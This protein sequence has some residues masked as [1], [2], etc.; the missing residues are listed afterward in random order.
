MKGRIGKYQITGQIG[1]GGMGKIYK[2]VGPSSNKEIIIKQLKVSAK[3]V[4]VKRFQREADIMSRFSHPNIVKVFERFSDDGFSYIAMEYID[5]IS[6]EELIKKR[7]VLSTP[8]SLLILYQVCQGLK[9]AHDRGVIHRDIKPDN[10]LISKR[11]DVKLC[12]FGIAGGQPGKDEPLTNTGVVMGTPAY[13]S[14]EQL[15]SAKYLDIRSDIY[16]LGVAFYQMI[17]GC[18][19]FPS[20][21]SKETVEKIT[22]GIFPK[23]EKENPDIPACFRQIIRKTMNRKIQKRYQDLGELIDYLA[24]FLDEFNSRG[25]INVAIKHYV[26]GKEIKFSAFT[27]KTAS[28]RERQKTRIKSPALNRG[29]NG[30]SGIVFNDETYLFNGKITV[31]RAQNNNIVIRDDCMVSRRHAELSKENGKCFMVDFSVN[32]TYLNGKRLAK[33]SKTPVCSGDIV[34]LGKSI[35]EIR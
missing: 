5:G 31:G 35:L 28:N 19:P 1:Q 8:A 10:I 14:P 24:D 33:D 11:G 7:T 22:K 23:P 21:F 32:G 29:D 13:M 6:L 30:P 2:G 26:E 25:K 4:L 9:Y 12:D 3:A 34:S 17:T 15:K 27:A 20:V 16:S 18:K